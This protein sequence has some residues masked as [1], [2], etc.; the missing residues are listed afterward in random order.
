MLVVNKALKALHPMNRFRAIQYGSK[1]KKEA[2]SD[3]LFGIV[4]LAVGMW[5]INQDQELT[6]KIIGNTSLK[7]NS[8]KDNSRLQELLSKV[9]LGIG[10]ILVLLACN[11][12]STGSAKFGVY[13]GG[14]IKEREQQEQQDRRQQEEKEGLVVSGTRAEAGAGNTPSFPPSTSFSTFIP[15]ERAVVEQPSTSSMRS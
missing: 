1:F 3:F 7:N 12:I 5:L 2:I 14:K 6:G 10:I 8:V 4:E 9:F 13:R 15:Q 11:N